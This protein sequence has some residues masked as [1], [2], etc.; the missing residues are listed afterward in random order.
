MLSVLKHLV[1]F[2]CRRVL[3]ML[4]LNDSLRQKSV[5]DGSES[6][7]SEAYNIE[8]GHNS[9]ELVLRLMSCKFAHDG[10]LR[11]LTSDGEFCSIYRQINAFLKNLPEESKPLLIVHQISVEPAETFLDRFTKKAREGAYNFM[12]CSQIVFATQQN[13][14][15]DINE[16]SCIVQAA[17]RN[18]WVASGRGKEVELWGSRPCLAPFLIVDAC[19]SFAAIPTFLDPSSQ[20][21]YLAGLLKHAGYVLIFALCIFV[22][23]KYST[24]TCI[25]FRCGPNATFVR[26][27]PGVTLSPILTGWLADL[28]V[29]MLM[30]HTNET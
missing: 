21:F 27:P 19:H 23:S 5:T 8:W 10:A 30:S 7:T 26:V 28:S 14:I 6:S 3:D 24:V 16:F 20:V 13:I 11:I 15:P 9:H 18:G 17:V 1:A 12:Y 29:C 25:L 2:S 22:V 4:S